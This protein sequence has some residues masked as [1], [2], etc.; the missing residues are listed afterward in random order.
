MF[1]EERTDWGFSSA[2]GEVGTAQALGWR[3]GCADPARCG[4]GRR[5]KGSTMALLRLVSYVHAE[6]I[7]DLV[8]SQ[9]TKTFYESYER[10]SVEAAPIGDMGVYY[11]SC[12]EDMVVQ[13]PV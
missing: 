2:G 11:P 6:G 5:V 7:K 9:A 4:G 1:F 12:F 10:H 3:M 13:S 8:G